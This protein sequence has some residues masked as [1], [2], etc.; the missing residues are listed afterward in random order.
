MKFAGQIEG[1]QVDE[2]GATPTILVE[3]EESGSNE[4]KEDKLK[5]AIFLGCEVCDPL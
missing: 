1:L 3:D 4:L 5:V 2:T